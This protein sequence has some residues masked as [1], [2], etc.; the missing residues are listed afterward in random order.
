MKMKRRNRIMRRNG[1]VIV[2]VLLS[3]C[4]MVTACGALDG[5]ESAQNEGMTDPA[6][7][8]WQDRNEEN[9]M[10]EKTEEAEE[11]EPQTPSGE[12]V[13][14]MRE[15]V[16]E[17][18]SQEEV[19]RLTE[20]IKVADSQM[21]NAYLYEN[22]F[23]KLSDPDSLYWQYF[24]QEGDIQ[25]GWWYNGDIRDME[26]I[27]KNEGLTEEEVREKYEP[28][29]VY[30]RFDADNFIELIEDMQASVENELLRSDLQ[31]LIDLTYMAAATHEMEYANQ[32][33]KILHDMDYYLLRYGLEDVGKYVEDAGLL[34]EYYGVLKVY[35][36]TPFS[37]PAEEQPDDSPQNSRCDRTGNFGKQ[38]I[39][40][41][42]IE[43]VNEYMIP[44][45]SFDITLDDWGDV[46][47]AS[48]R[49]P[50]LDEQAEEV[51]GFEDASFYL[52]KGNQIL[53]RFPYRYENNSSKSYGGL[54]TDV[55]AVSFRDIN[56]DQKKDIIII[57]Y[58]VSG[59]GPT[60]MVPRPGIR[61]FIA[62]DHEFYLD[63][64]IMTDIEQ[65]ILKKDM[66]IGNICNYL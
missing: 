36:A 62:G 12:E 13:L 63:E 33:Y 43:K 25:I 55:G 4:F 52:L 44:E 59:V 30:N 39:V 24:D 65:N 27:M 51:D 22:L 47:F 18:M 16:L 45:Q 1:I 38:G 9:N 32:I 35:G 29:I 66:T 19:E 14:A 28:G 61:I 53:Y 58:Y 3:L 57:T 21:E 15:T 8:V 54:Y 5:E 37:L 50:A 17:G 23:D 2:S 46:T 7:T 20:N 64:N 60:G 11:A 49:P 26:I 40:R 48:C 56:N 42:S 41:D 31:Q 6:D 10:A 34:A